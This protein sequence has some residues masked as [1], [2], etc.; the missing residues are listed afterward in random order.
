MSKIDF[1]KYEE[2]IKKAIESKNIHLEIKEPLA[3]MDGFINLS[4][5]K[6]LTGSIVIGGPSLPIIAAVGKNTGR[7]YLFALKALLPDVELK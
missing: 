7:V 3:L 6:K 5:N 4:L 2:A 1:A